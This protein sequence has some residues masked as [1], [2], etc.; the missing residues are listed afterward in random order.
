MSPLSVVRQ[1]GV[2]LLTLDTARLDAPARAALLAALDA[3]GEAPDVGALVIGTA[4]PGFPAAPDHPEALADPPLALLCDRI[5]ACPRPVVLALQG[6]VLGGALELALAAHGRV[7]DAAARLGFPEVALGLAPGAGGTQRLPRLVGAEAALRLLT[8]GRPIR[9][10]EALA[11]GLLDRV[12]EE[13]VTAAARARAADLAAAGPP[14]PA[15]TRRDGFRDPVAYSAA[16]AAARQATRHPH[17]PAAARLVDCVEAALLLPPEAGFTFERAAA[18]DLADSPAARGL[19]HARAIERAA[20]LPAEPPRPL[21]TV[22]LAGLGPDGSALVLALLG[23]G[24][25]V[26]LVDPDRNR[27]IAG[28]EAVAFA[29]EAAVGK[30]TL[31]P[32]QRDADWVRLA[33]RL[34]PEALAGADLVLDRRAPGA[35]P[36]AAVLHPGAVL[37][38]SD[39]AA[40]AAPA[41]RAADTLALH[42]PPLPLGARLMELAAGPATDPAAL[43]TA[44][45]LARRLN[46]TPVLGR[47][48]FA[49]ATVQ[50]A[51]L[52]AAEITLLGGGTPATLD[53]ALRAWGCA[54]GP[55]AL[56]DL[57]G[58]A[59]AASPLS[60]HLA[61]A[62]RL[63]LASGAGWLAWPAGRPEGQDDPVVLNF[64]TAARADRPPRILPPAAI[65]RRVLLAM[66][67]VGARL[68]EAGEVARPADIDLAMITGYGF[69]RWRGGPMLQAD[70]AGL[71]RVRRELLDLAGEDPLWAPPDLLL[72]LIKNGR[73]FADLNDGRI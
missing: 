5:E 12:V 47:G 34:D 71:V 1:D 2:A 66:I 51:A 69:P 52:A 44:A 6:P 20:R 54:Q 8:R 49:G 33:G 40:L 61:A 4:R 56:A 23:A 31:S 38:L 14:Q 62:G 50:A 55:C 67:A 30:G 32:E 68:L 53:A 19:H 9:A 37:A 25:S 73:S 21:A 43:A 70:L 35:P 63:G 45:A 46:R 58:L 57:A 15:R 28:L 13:D 17:L 41:D 36:L 3:L 24:L 27:L 48:A 29:Q 22:G 10:A 26:I 18:E 64:L 16:V 11:L 39:P 60:G 59:G 72:D 42:L 7:A 65:A